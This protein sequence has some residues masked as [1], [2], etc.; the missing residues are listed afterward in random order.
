MYLR[1]LRHHAR[2]PRLHVEV[3]KETGAPLTVVEIAIRRMQQA[4]HDATQQQDDN[5]K[6]DQVWGVFDVDEHPNLDRAKAL[7]HKNGVA[8]A[9]SNPCFELWALLH[10][11]DQTA[12]IERDR[13]RAA[14]QHHLPGYDKELDF[15]KVH[16]TYEQAVERAIHLDHQADTHD[17]SGRNPTTHVYKLTQVILANE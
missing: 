16:P 3:A 8:L 2:N 11:Q 15:S 6:W 1:A 12:H 14:L 4:E 13:V 5:L 9:I 10:F 17:E 7:A